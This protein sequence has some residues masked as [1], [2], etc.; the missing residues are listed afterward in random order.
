MITWEKVPPTVLDLAREIINE[1]H[2]HLGYYRIGFVFRSE[3]LKKGGR[4]AIG[5]TSKV[6]PKYSAHVDL[7]FIIWL[8]KDAWDNLTLMQRK[9]LI[10]HELCHISP[11]G[12]LL[13]HDIEEFTEIIKRYGLW[14]MDLLR[15]DTAFEQA[16]QLQ[17]NI[18]EPGGVVAVDP[19]DLPATDGDE[20]EDEEAREEAESLESLA[21]DAPSIHDLTPAEL[22]ERATGNA[23]ASL[24][25]ICGQEEA[26]QNG[27]CLGC[28]GDRLAAVQSTAQ[29]SG[30]G[31]AES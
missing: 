26:V 19:S 15:A 4:L 17:L 23:P 28:L 5:N 24:C 11:A 21:E 2:H 12:R 20:G 27:L 8:A 7:N 25:T 29:E 1:Y 22:A 13:S 30:D 18:G 14:T 6:S 10:D 16:R 3:P 31:E 9:A